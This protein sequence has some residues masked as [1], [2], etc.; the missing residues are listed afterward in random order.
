VFLAYQPYKGPAA[1]PHVPGEFFGA[2]F[3]ATNVRYIPI[4][5]LGY[6]A[7]DRD[8][9]PIPVPVCSADCSPSSYVPWQ[10]L[11]QR[12]ESQE[13]GVSAT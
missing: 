1:I 9:D 5:F 12:V 6:R 10:H 13:V 8:A 3:L 7:Q 11:R 2:F 4:V